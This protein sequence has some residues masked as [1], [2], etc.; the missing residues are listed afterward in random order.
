MAMFINPLSCQYRFNVFKWWPKREKSGQC[1][2]FPFVRPHLFGYA[3]WHKMNHLHFSDITVEYILYFTHYGIHTTLMIVHYY[4]PI[5]VSHSTC[6][7]LYLLIHA[8]T[9][10]FK[11]HNEPKERYWA[12]LR[13]G[14]TF[15]NK[16]SFLLSG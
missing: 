15:S 9:A 10:T 2:N 6:N 8:I 1:V 4:N 12:H 3:F 7:P 14:E 13:K 11:Q 5:R 16:F